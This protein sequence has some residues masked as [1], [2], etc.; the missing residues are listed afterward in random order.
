MMKEWRIKNNINLKEIE[1]FLAL[2][3]KSIN[4]KENKTLSPIDY[5]IINVLDVRWSMN[6]TIKLLSLFLNLELF[7]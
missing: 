4:K 5:K 2:N 3:L 6:N 7:T 1:I